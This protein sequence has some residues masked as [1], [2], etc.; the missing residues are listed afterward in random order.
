MKIKL[1]EITDAA[2]LVLYHKINNAHLKAWEPEREANFHDIDNWTTRLVQQQ[3]EQKNGVS[4][5][6]LATE[7]NTNNILA[8]CNLSNIIYGPFR[9]CFIG[10]SV[11]KEHQ[12]K[13]IM[14]K[15]CSRVLEYAFNELNLNR[16]MANYMPGNIRSE[17]LLTSLGFE[18]EGFAKRY[19]KINGVWEDHVLT[20]LIKP[21]DHLPF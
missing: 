4:F 7:D 5:L 9:A 8:T 21:K 16:L 18:K 15:L 1:A 6:F 13:G 14:K 17:K 11:S 10:F 20:S 19:L 3:N 2:N 12:G